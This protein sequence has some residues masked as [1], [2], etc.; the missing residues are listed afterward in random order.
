MLLAPLNHHTH[1]DVKCLARVLY[2]EA[3]GESQR[4]KLL[5]AEVV[6]NRVKDPRWPN[7]VCGVTQQKHQFVGK[8][9]NKELLALSL[10]IL[11]GRVELP[12]TG[13]VYFNPGS[14]V[15]KT[16]KLVAKEGGHR[17]YK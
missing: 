4:G 16:T 13:A 14:K 6:V 8:R 9:Y 17:F 3:R 5:V 7:T 11:N 12:R 2:S 1:E 15:V 10:N